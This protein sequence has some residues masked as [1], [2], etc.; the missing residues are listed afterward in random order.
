M[1]HDKRVL[2]E[3]QII[4]AA[5]RIF[6]K[7]GF[8]N[9]KMEDIAREAKITKVTLYS[10]FQS[11]ENLYLAITYTGFQ[12]LLDAY[13]KSIEKNK[14]NTG[15]EATLAILETNMNFFRENFLYSE[16][17]LEYFSIIRTSDQG[18]NKSK[19]TDAI[20]DSMFFNKLQDIQ[21]LPFKLSFQ[22]IERGKKDGSILSTLDSMHIALQG[23]TMVTGFA[24]ILSASGNSVKPLFKVDLMELKNT[25]LQ[26]AR[27]LLHSR[28]L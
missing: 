7:F 1:K 20:R 18:L 28:E 12:K 16:A 13:Y 6:N 11:K 14:S 5:E 26:L 17:L 2:K 23:W 9:A 3:N 25:T 4:Q 24:K 22:E 15:L 19:L 21:N 10:Y 27:L 8:R